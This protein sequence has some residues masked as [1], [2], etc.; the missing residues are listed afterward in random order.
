MVAGLTLISIFYIVIA[1]FAVGSFFALPMIW[2][3]EGHASRKLDRII[4][5][6]EQ[7]KEEVK[8]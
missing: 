4:K 3:H 5:I 2:Y 8:Q 1:I 7:R 6:L